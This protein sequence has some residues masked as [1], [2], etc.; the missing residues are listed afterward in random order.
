MLYSQIL[1]HERS[2]TE[3][4]RCHAVALFDQVKAGQQPP[5]SPYD[6][7]L[8][9][10]TIAIID[11]GIATQFEQ[12]DAY[13]SSEF[14]VMLQQGMETIAVDDTLNGRWQ[15]QD[16]RQVNDYDLAMGYD[17]D[18]FAIMHL[19]GYVNELIELVSQQYSARQARTTGVFDLTTDTN[20]DRRWAEYHIG[21]RVKARIFV[22][23]E[24]SQDWRTG[25]LHLSAHS[26]R[27][28][29]ED[30]KGKVYSYVELKTIK[31]VSTEVETTCL[32]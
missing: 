32:I 1:S 5:V 24:I 4:Q 23:Y 26:E 7:M 28:N 13:F 18:E 21:C 14:V 2:R 30:E 22:P 15:I 6:R 31:A 12:D 8:L 16:I 29:L 17:Y 19:D 27:Y 10:T 25:L 3:A 20:E 11:R 9:E